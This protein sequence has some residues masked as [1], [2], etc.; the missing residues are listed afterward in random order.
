M[1]DTFLRLG[2]CIYRE[3]VKEMIRQEISEST[4]F[5]ENVRQILL[6][7]YIQQWRSNIATGVQCYKY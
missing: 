1:K 2:S 3:D 7:Q 5:N 4:W 6:D